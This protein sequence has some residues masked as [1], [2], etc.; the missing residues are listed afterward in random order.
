MKNL[1]NVSELLKRANAALELPNQNLP[2][3]DE[4]LRVELAQRYVN[5]AISLREQK[6][7]AQDIGDLRF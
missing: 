4:C 7:I 5:L 1:L 6:P 2:P 3:E